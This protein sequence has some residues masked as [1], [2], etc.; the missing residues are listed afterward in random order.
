M[1]PEDIWYDDSQNVSTWNGNID[2]SYTS[3][4]WGAFFERIQQ[5]DFGWRVDAEGP[6]HDY[7]SRL[8]SIIEAAELENPEEGEREPLL[9]LNIGME[10]VEKRAE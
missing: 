3:Y 7:H 2:R 1:G 10:L 8:R 6:I 9:L 4:R 5:C